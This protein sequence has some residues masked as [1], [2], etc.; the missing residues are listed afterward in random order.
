MTI[1]PFLLSI[2]LYFIAIIVLFLYKPDLMHVD[3]Y[4]KSLLIIIMILIGTIS[5]YISYIYNM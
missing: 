3:H 5:Y 4:Q 2:I 1:T